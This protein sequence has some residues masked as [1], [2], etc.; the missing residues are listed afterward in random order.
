MRRWLLLDDAPIGRKGPTCL[1]ALV[2]TIVACLPAQAKAASPTVTTEPTLR[3]GFSRAVTDYVARCPDRSLSITVRRTRGARVRVA[4]RPYSEPRTVTIE[5]GQ[6]VPIRVQT[7]RRVTR[8][9]VRCLPDDFPGWTYRRV[10][11]QIPR[12]YF[13]T[14]GAPIGEPT[15]RLMAIFDHRGVP[16]WWYRSAAG[17]DIHNVHLIDGNIAYAEAN[18]GGFGTNPNF[19]YR[20]RRPDGRLVRTIRTVGSPTDFH[21]LQRVGRDYLILTYRPRDHVDLTAYG[22]PSDATVLDSEIQRINPRGRV[23]WSW[24]SRDHVDLAETGR[25]WDF[26]INMPRSL[27]DGRQVYDPTHIN[28][29][30][31]VGRDLIISMRHTDAIYRIRM[32]G[33]R[34]RWKLGGTQ[35]PRSLRVLGDSADYPFGGQ[36]DARLWRGSLTVYDNGTDLGRPPRAVRFAIDPKRRRAILRESVIDLSVAESQCCG[37]ARKLENGDWL[38]GWGGE[39]VSS[40][41]SPSGGLVSRLAFD[42]GFSSYR[43]VPTPMGA[44]SAGRLRGAM[45]EMHPA[46][47]G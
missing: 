8:H 31:V 10:G 38:V 26:V 33:G 15:G 41:L 44:I 47:A 21:D 43:T 42:D 22:G 35:T 1:V 14:P 20:I 29:V 27:P 6:A 23:V 3:P 2:L 45:D 9:F 12:W 36:H 24:S 16:V 28:S 46:K 18:R 4:G 17:D 5:P 13:V 40:I 11:P 7:R 39:G 19:A 37:S 25:W 30:E 32:R 34:I